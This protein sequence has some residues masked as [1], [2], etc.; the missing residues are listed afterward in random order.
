M[1][2]TDIEYINR[3]ASDE[4]VEIIVKYNGDISILATELNAFVEILTPNFAIIT[5]HI[6]QVPN[7]YRFPQI[8]YIEPPKAL[9]YVLTD[10]LLSIC[11]PPIQ[12]P[13]IYG[14]RGNGVLV[15]LIDSGIDLMHPDFQNPDGTSRVV[16]LWD[17]TIQGNPPSG[18]RSGAEYNN[19]EINLS[20]SN[21]DDYSP[22]PADDLIGHGTA[23]AGIMA[24]NGASSN[25][26]E[27]GVA[28]NAS[29]IVVKLN[30]NTPQFFTKTTE[31]MRGI[32]YAIDKSLELQMPLVIN[33][34]YGTS[35][36]AHNGNSL[37]EL[38][39]DEMSSIGKT[40]IC[41]AVGN[42]GTSR[43]HYSAIL[44]TGEIDNIAFSISE[45]HSQVYITAWKDFADNIT[46]ELIAPNGR[47]TGPITAFESLTRFYTT[48][49]QVTILYLQ[50]NHYNVQQEIYFN[51]N[52]IDGAAAIG[53]WHIVA[54]GVNIVNGLL[55]MW[56]P[57]TEYISE[58]TAFLTSN[59]NNTITIPSTARNV[60]SVGGYNSI[61]NTFAIF[62]GR[63]SLI[64]N[65]KPDLVAP[66]VNILT[67]KSRGGYDTFTGTSMASPF[68]AGCAALMMEWGIVRGNDTFL[69]GQ[70]IKAFLRRGAYRSVTLNYP[71]NRWGYGI[72]N[73]CDTMDSLV[74]FNQ[75]GGDLF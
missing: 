26:R 13:N 51:F 46:F 27:V 67:T 37:F 33:L 17:Q 64:Y 3:F 24:G 12:N 2:E 70:R 5:L 16:Y 4:Y 25:Q 22:F 63:G 28:P 62:S 10:N 36:G 6:S 49:A 66:A 20:I 56:L 32:K 71:N 14:L 58:R 39:I 53:T 44:S 48:G 23:V 11:V 45:V 29:I 60:I 57:T 30:N 38:F 42:E 47:S 52:I 8:E 59:V 65:G 72:L 41:V 73:L 40:S 69:Y 35:E 43:H 74:E 9:S 18:F 31:V 15:A 1:D 7:L 55:N 54:T 34:S 50:P 75:Y 19:E 68:V 21:P 61:V